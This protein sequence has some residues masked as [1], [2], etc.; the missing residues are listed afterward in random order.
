[1]YCNLPGL[2]APR[3]STQRFVLVGMGSEADLHSPVFAGQALRG[4]SVAYQTAELMPTVTRV[5][6]VGMTAAGEWPVYCLV[7]QHYTAGMRATLLVQ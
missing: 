2:R 6:D 1:M 7:Q 4:K 3:G 5:V